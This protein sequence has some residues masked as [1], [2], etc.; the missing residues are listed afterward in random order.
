MAQEA[1]TDEAYTDWGDYVLEDDEDEI[2]YEPTS[3][4]V[5][6][7]SGTP[8][9]CY[10]VTVGEIIQGGG[11]SYRI[12]HKLGRGTFSLVWLAFEMGASVSVALKIHNRS[13]SQPKESSGASIPG[14]LIESGVR[15]D[16]HQLISDPAR[17]SLLTDF[18]TFTLPGRFPGDTHVVVVL[19][20]MGPNLHEYLD[21]P[22]KLDSSA[23]LRLAKDCLTAV[24]CLHAH[25][26]VHRGT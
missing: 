15:Q 11:K 23:R 19:P 10:P 6:A 20:L 18:S 7:Y 9:P 4:G 17:C 5:N 2:A 24:A 21:S 25:E 1:R 12:E 3:E 26:Y 16:L 8:P 13:R 14:H 22:V